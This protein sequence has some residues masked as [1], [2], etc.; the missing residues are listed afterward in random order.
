MTRG[1]AMGGV[2]DGISA[3]SE[4]P[5]Y[6]AT[7]PKISLAGYV[8]PMDVW[9]HLAVVVGEESG[10]SYHVRFYVDGVLEKTGTLSG[11]FLTVP[12]LTAAGFSNY[13]C[14]WCDLMVFKRALTQAEVNKIFTWRKKKEKYLVP[15]GEANIRFPDVQMADNTD[16]LFEYEMIVTENKASGVRRNLG[17]SRNFVSFWGVYT[18]PALSSMFEIHSDTRLTNTSPILLN[19]RYNV[20]W[21]YKMR[22]VSTPDAFTLTVKDGEGNLIQSLQKQGYFHPNYFGMRYNLFGLANTLASPDNPSMAC[23]DGL[24]FARVRIHTNGVLISDC[25]AVEQGSTKWSPTPAPSNCL[26]D[27]VTGAY[28]TQTQGTGSFSIV[29]W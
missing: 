26:W 9:K 4:L 15:S 16:M 29:E 11:A 22:T 17:F 2:N 25:V 20:E 6:G 12:M 3:W 14:D 23:V 27:K 10:G 8:T 24:G 21:L 5:T 1:M 18:S 7:Q 19:T 28:R 13:G